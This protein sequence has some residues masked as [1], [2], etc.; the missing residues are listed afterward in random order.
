[1][2]CLTLYRRDTSECPFYHFSK[3]NFIDCL[4]EFPRGHEWTLKYILEH[5]LPNFTTEIDLPCGVKIGELRKRKDSMRAGELQDLHITRLLT[6]HG[7]YYIVYRLENCCQINNP[8]EVVS[9]I[10]RE[11]YLTTEGKVYFIPDKIY[12]KSRGLNL[13]PIR[14]IRSSYGQWYLLIGE[15][16]NLYCLQT[17]RNSSRGPPDLCLGDG[18]VILETEEFRICQSEFMDVLDA[19][20]PFYNVVMILHHDGNFECY[21]I[22]HYRKSKKIIGKIDNVREMKRINCVRWLLATGDGQVILFSILEDVTMF[23][24]SLYCTFLTLPWE[25]FWTLNPPVNSQVKSARV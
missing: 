23:N 21:E 18:I 13:P 10:C 16:G 1:M 14:N 5:G 8:G 25:G 17:P 24:T 22:D 3:G 4:E 12:D 20:C 11:L 15:D 7:D 19:A 6:K 9:K 2:A